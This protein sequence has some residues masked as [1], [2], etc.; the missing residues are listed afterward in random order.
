MQR[1]ARPLVVVGI[2]STAIVTNT[3]T[4]Y[5]SEVIFSGMQ[6]TQKAME[7]YNA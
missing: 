3:R 1:H 2:R 4:T 6:N 7:R 5:T